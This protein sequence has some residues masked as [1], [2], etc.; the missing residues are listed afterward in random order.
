MEETAMWPLTSPT[1]CYSGARNIVIT[2][3]EASGDDTTSSAATTAFVATALHSLRLSFQTQRTSTSSPNETDLKV[4]WEPVDDNNPNRKNRI[5]VGQASNA[6]YTVM[7]LL[8]GLEHFVQSSNNEIPSATLDDE[9]AQQLRELLQAPDNHNQSAALTVATTETDTASVTASVVTTETTTSTPTTTTLPTHARRPS[10]TDNMDAFASSTGSITIGGENSSTVAAA[11]AAESSMTHHS[12]TGTAAL[13]LLPQAPFDGCLVWKDAH[14]DMT[15][16]RGTCAIDFR[17][18]CMTLAPG[19]GLPI[20]VV[21][22]D[23]TAMQQQRPVVF[24]GSADAARL[25]A[26]YWQEETAQLVPMTMM[27]TTNSGGGGDN[28]K[29]DEDAENAFEVAS[30]VMAID[31]QEITTINNTTTTTTKTDTSTTSPSYFVALA[32]QDGTFR[33]IQIHHYNAS[34]QSWK[35]R[36]VSQVMVDGPLVCLQFLPGTT[37]AL[38][39]SLCGYVM[40]LENDYVAEES[41]HEGLPRLVASELFLP[42]DQQYEAEDGMEEE[43]SVLAVH[44]WDD[45]VAIGTQAGALLLYHKKATTIVGDGHDLEPL[46][47]KAGAWRLPYSVHEICRT[48]QGHDDQLLVTTRKSIHLFSLHHPRPKWDADLAKERVKRLL[49]RASIDYWN[50]NPSS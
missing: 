18:L 3:G 7:A 15:T 24:M 13:P 36:I 49:E 26:Y 22:D 1:T 8:A 41:S 10:S 39:G 42:K 25:L 35:A 12:S 46:Y 11:A 32:C 34:T 27:T 16:I 9:T 17:P 47:V 4:T 20:V 14:D 40:L 37:H 33:C 5:C 44:G 21:Q 23:Q 43:D 38:V 30:P 29:D 6:Q 48:G 50:E 45:W 19:E 2:V 28:D 31:V